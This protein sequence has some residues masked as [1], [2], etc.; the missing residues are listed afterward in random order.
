MASHNFPMEK[1]NNKSILKTMVHLGSLSSH[2]TAY[3]WE[4]DILILKSCSIIN[5]HAM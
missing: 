5:K 1:Q 3:I 2:N 4:Y